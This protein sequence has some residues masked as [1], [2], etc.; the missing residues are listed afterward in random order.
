MSNIFGVIVTLIVAYLLGSIPFGLIIGLFWK[1]I[2][3]RDHGSGN[4]GVSNVLR[5]VGKLPALIALV[6]DVGKGSVAVLLAKQFFTNPFIWLLVGCAAIVGHSWSIFLK[7]KGGRS[8]AT[9][10]GVLIALSPVIALTLLLV[11]LITLAIS[12][13]ISLSSITAAIALPITVYIMD[14]P[15]GYFILAFLL[16]LVVVLRHRPNI[17]RLLA[18]EEYRIGQKARKI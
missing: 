8:V 9:S 2:D 1:K 5:T 12:R 3:V 10:W 11:W 16:G 14:Y 17:K 13:Y 18:G 6:F 4:I 15:T 7:F